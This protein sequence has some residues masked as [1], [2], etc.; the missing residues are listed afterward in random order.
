M[1]HDNNGDNDRAKSEQKTAYQRLE[2]KMNRIN[3]LDHARAI[4]GWDDAV[5]M[6]PGGAEARA[7]AQAELSILRLETLS[8]SDVGQA[9][10]QA[11]RDTHLNEWQK[12]NVREILRLYKGATVLNADFAERSS[13][14]CMASENAWRKLRAANDWKSFAPY[15][16]N[17]VSLAREEAKMRSDAFDLPLYDAMLDIYEP[18]LRS[19]TIERVFTELKSVLPGI[20]ETV[21]A[22]QSI[23][24]IVEL[25]RPV[26]VEKQKHMMRFFMEWL[27]FDFQH[28]RLDESHHPF[29]G[30]VSSDVRMTTRYNPED[31]FSG[32]MGVLHET[33][34]ALYEMGLPKEWSEQP[35][36]SARGMAFHESQSLFVEMQISRS[37]EFIEFA[38]PKLKESLAHPQDPA[39]FWTVEN[40]TRLNNK[41]ERGWIR[42]DADEVTY[43]LHII[44]RY[45]IE[46]ALI[47]GT[48]EVKDLPEIWNQKMQLYLGIT[49]T[50]NDKNGCMQDVHWP[51]GGFGYFPCYTLGAMT[52]AQLFA[53]LERDLPNAR[54]LVKSG[55]V[56]GILGWTKKNV[57]QFGSL[58]LSEDLLKK[59][60]GSTLS[61][62]PFLNHLNKRYL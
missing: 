61:T 3:R 4:L 11:Q 35:V 59:A 36:G 17:V 47:E 14:A 33:G 39:D 12:A 1:N 55:A 13:R 29:C 51:S 15:L 45:E 38:L 24:K 10:E 37:R 31:F 40:L 54:Q 6:P 50:G 53:S 30:G 9:L 26:P 56:Q 60:T 8:H 52:A 42:V 44:L 25:N 18:G 46:K 2:A 21:I 5:M 19:T 58:Y 48:L 57:A 27:G 32:L 7:S 62:E 22:K 20:A 43:P 23:Q 49:T 41:V 16:Q 34:H 28:G